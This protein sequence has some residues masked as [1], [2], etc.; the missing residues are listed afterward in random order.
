MTYAQSIRVVSCF[1]TL[2][3]LACELAEHD[4]TIGAALDT[5]NKAKAEHRALFGTLRTYV[6]EFG[7][8]NWV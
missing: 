1:E 5:F 6:D 3:Q 4:D 2:Y 8:K 7:Q